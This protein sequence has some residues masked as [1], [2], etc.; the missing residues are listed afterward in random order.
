VSNHKLRS[1][2]SPSIDEYGYV[3]Q[4]V[5]FY[6]CA[7]GW[8][9]DTTANERDALDDFRHHL[10]MAFAHDELMHRVERQMTQPTGVI[11]NME[12]S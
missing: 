9:Q 10:E 3:R 6:Y 7:C 11:L 5:N 12:S 8:H 4:P 1:Y 2:R